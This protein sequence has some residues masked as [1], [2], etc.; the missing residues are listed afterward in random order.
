VIEGG[1]EGTMKISMDCYPCFLRQG[2]EASRIAGAD[3]KMQERILH[4]IMSALMKV[5][6][7]ET[8]PHIGRLIQ[9]TVRE[10]TGNADPYKE[11]KKFHNEQMLKME[12]DLVRL[13]NES[14]SPLV[15]ALKLAGTGNL[16][17]MGPERQWK[18]IAEIFEDVTTKNADYFDHSSFESFLKNAGTLLYI[19]DN[20]G[21]IVLD[22]ILICFLIENTALDIIYAV[23]G[24]PIINDVTVEDAEFVGMTD[25]V[26]VI[27]T[28]AD[29]PGV[30]LNSC[31]VEFLDNYYGADMILAKGQGNYESLSD[32]SE[33]IF[34]LLQAK[35]SLIARKLGC[36]VGDMILRKQPR[37]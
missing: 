32:E 37:A 11:I 21:E 34:F 27:N 25:I 6:R 10:V 20:A 16:I 26:R 22:K 13:I 35:C 28:G 1:K 8:P 36:N 9:S 24:N 18:N 12:A 29:F 31:S 23:R 14:A 4:S 33:N 2:L 15:T 3:E 30:D 17:D 5:S 19:G 7:D